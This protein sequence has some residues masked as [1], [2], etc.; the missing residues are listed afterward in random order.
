MSFASQLAMKE[1]QPV[2]PTTR[3]PGRKVAVGSLPAMV[4]PVAPSAAVMRVRLQGA[5]VGSLGTRAA[6]NT[7]RVSP[8]AS[9]SSSAEPSRDQAWAPVRPA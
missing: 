2:L 4:G 1:P 6:V 8:V 5:I 9:F 3:P 7:S